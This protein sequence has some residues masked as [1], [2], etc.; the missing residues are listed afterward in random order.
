LRGTLSDFSPITKTAQVQA[1]FRRSVIGFRSARDAFRVLLTACGITTGDSIL[2]PSFI[3]WS[4]REGSGVY[5]PVASIGAE[6]IF[7]RMNENLSIDADD[8]QCKIRMRKPRVLVLIHY[9]GYPDPNAAALAA[10]AHK[11]G[12]LVLEDEAHAMLSD[13]V[14]GA[15]GRTG[16]AVIFSLHKMLPFREGGCF[17]SI[18][19]S[20]MAC[21]CSLRR[22]SR[23]ANFFRSGSTIFIA[24]LQSGGET[25]N[26]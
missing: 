5:D 24:S 23:R 13:L 6:S 25:L 10:Y 12:V 19:Q 3:G 4:A 15:C 1:C 16:D 7:Y 21:E 2:L 18:R 22:E 8:V 17:C 11:H 26:S 14:G 9:F 20:P